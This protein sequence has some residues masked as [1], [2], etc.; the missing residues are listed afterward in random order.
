M[1]VR[2][3][4]LGHLC[5]APLLLAGCAA[6]GLRTPAAIATSAGGHPSKPVAMQHYV[7]P[8][9][10]ISS[11]GTAIVRHSPVYP[12]AL[13]AACP[14]LVRVRA[15]VSVDGA[16]R[17][18]EV[19]SMVVDDAAATARW[20]PFL[21]AVRVAVMTWRFNPLQVTHWA[22]DIDGNSHVVDSADE[23]FDRFYVFRF[24]CHAGKP[25]VSVEPVG[26]APGS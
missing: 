15:R 13:L 24:A 16:G 9:G 3:A 25:V 7:L 22:A 17:V 2:H 6:A 20:Q 8:M 4:R 11:G 21:L 12:A 5:C 1:A 18:R 10:D 19:R 14:A 26:T 23:P